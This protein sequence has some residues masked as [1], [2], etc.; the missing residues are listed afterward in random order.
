MNPN[1]RVT[2]LL[3]RVLQR[4]EDDS[5]GSFFAKLDDLAGDNSDRWDLL[6]AA[7][8]NLQIVGFDKCRF[9]IEDGASLEGLKEV[10]ING[11]FNLAQIKSAHQLVGPGSALMYIARGSIVAKRLVLS[12]CFLTLEKTY[13]AVYEKRTHSVVLDD[14]SDILPTDIL[15]V[16]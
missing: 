3:A 7:C 4:L 5:D 8:H 1:V 12:G 10:K 11:S 2:R 14:I 6:V 16:R 13:V 15:L 9:P